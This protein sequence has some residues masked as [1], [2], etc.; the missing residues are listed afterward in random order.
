MVFNSSIAFPKPPRGTKGV[1][2]ASMRMSPMGCFTVVGRDWISSR[3]AYCERTSVERCSQ[4]W[5]VPGAW[6]DGE[7]QRLIK[8]RQ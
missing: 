8:L 3:C 7:L 6:W 1:A 4:V 2:M 5:K